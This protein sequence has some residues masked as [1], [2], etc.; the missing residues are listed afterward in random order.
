MKSRIGTAF[1]MKRK[2][3]ICVTTAL[4]V[5]TIA[6]CVVFHWLSSID[7]VDNPALL[8]DVSKHG[9]VTLDTKDG[10]MEIALANT[11][12]AISDESTRQFD[13]LVAAARRDFV[14]FGM[15][16]DN[17]VEV[18]YQDAEGET[19]SLN[20]DLASL[21]NAEVRYVDRP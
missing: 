6:F 19:R 15:C 1:K 21:C 18:W 20:D 10:T 8:L 3:T 2:Q 7:F 5:M 14:A 9:V 16:S 11:N 13:R 4:I 12:V 17:T